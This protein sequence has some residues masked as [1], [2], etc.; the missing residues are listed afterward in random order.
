[1]FPVIYHANAISQAAMLKIPDFLNQSSAIAQINRFF[2]H[3]PGGLARP[4]RHPRTSYS[5]YRSYLSYCSRRTSAAPPGQ[6][7]SRAGLCQSV[8]ACHA[9]AL[10]RRVRVRPCVRA[11]PADL[12][13][14]FARSD[15]SGRPG[16]CRARH[17]ARHRAGHGA[18]HGARHGAGHRARHRA[19]GQGTQHIPAPLGRIGPICPISP[20][21]Q[22]P[23]K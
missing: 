6:L 3:I 12:Y 20:I 11:A 10:R 16:S 21:Y 19:S 9:V 13:S 22:P 1:M 2:K 5:S 4:V 8:L 7:S 14:L 23:K 15:I 17:R 18:G